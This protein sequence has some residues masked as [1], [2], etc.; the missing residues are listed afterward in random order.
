MKYKARRIDD[1]VWSD[2][3]VDEKKEINEVLERKNKDKEKVTER[4]D[5][6]RWKKN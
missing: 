6:L 5:I 1:G 2:I 4:G 3:D